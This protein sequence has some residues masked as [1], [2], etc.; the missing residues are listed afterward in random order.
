MM[1]T[2]NSQYGWWLRRKVLVRDTI[3][4]RVPLV[5]APKLISRVLEGQ[6]QAIKVMISA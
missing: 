4:H 5:E 6:E 1:P 2:L 3:T